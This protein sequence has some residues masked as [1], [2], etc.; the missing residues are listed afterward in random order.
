MAEGWTLTSEQHRKLRHHP[1][2]VAKITEL[3]HQLCDNA[4]S[5]ARSTRVIQ[6]RDKQGRF[7]PMTEKQS[8]KAQL[9]NFAVVVQDDTDTQRPRAYVHPVGKTGLR[10][11]AG[12]SVLFKALST[13]D[14]Q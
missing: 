4:N 7:L 9:D 5:I 13:M 6:P 12:E 8:A 14:R 11:E 10:V 3:A 1:A 2:V